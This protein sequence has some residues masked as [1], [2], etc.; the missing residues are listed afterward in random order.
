MLDYCVLVCGRDVG[1]L[2]LGLWKRCWITVSWFV[3]EMLDYCVLVCG[4][5]VGFLCLGL[6]KRC[7]IPVSWFV[8]E[9]LDSCVLVCGR[10]VG[11][12]C[13]GLWKRCW[14]VLSLF[15]DEMFYY[16]VLVCGIY[17]ELLCFGLW[18]RCWITVF[19]F[20][21]EILDYWVWFVEE[22]LDYCVSV[23]RRNI[24]LAQNEKPRVALWQ[25]N[26]KELLVV[27]AMKIF[28]IF[29]TDSILYFSLWKP[30]NADWI[31]LVTAIDVIC[32]WLITT[33]F[34]GLRI[35]IDIHLGDV[36]VHQPIHT[37]L[38]C[39]PWRKLACFATNS[40]LNLVYTL[41]KITLLSKTLLA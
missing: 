19:W 24:R 31:W 37:S 40:C 14:I 32:L 26:F 35:K 3:E 12:L 23:W 4:R 13:L 8:E 28:S 38:V 33:P 36:Q 15:V 17:V 25:N 16:C 34:I 39:V 29:D 20:V 27:K 22:I 7:W 6:W 11:F 18:K 2:C 9:I 41:S 10:D 21:E 5:D 30:M 1:F